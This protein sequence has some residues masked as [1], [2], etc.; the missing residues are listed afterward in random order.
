MSKAPKEKSAAPDLEAM[1]KRIDDVD[2]QIQ[3]LINERATY[4][5]QVGVTKG[6]LA[7]AVDYYRPEREAEV[8]RRVRER[9]AGPL[10]N[11]EMLR[12]FREIMSACLAQQDPLKV[13]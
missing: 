7:A 6:K 9:N 11:E 10:R 13:G 4:A 5:Q 12:L 1:R 3:A 8:L 2:V